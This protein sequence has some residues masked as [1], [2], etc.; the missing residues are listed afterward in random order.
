[1][2]DL[3]FLIEDNVLLRYAGDPDDRIVIP[4]G[5]REIGRYAFANNETVSEIILPEGVEV[6][7]ECAFVGCSWLT[8]IVLPKTLKR[9]E[10][11]A[12]RDCEALEEAKIP[13]GVRE[14][15]RSCFFECLSLKRVSF[16]EGLRVI[17]DKAFSGCT[18]ISEVIFGS[19]LIEIGDFSFELCAGIKR[20]SLPDGLEII[21]K[22]A[23]ASCHQLSDIE[24]PKTVKEIGSGAFYQTEFLESRNNELIIEGDGILLECKSDEKDIVIA[25]GVK[26]ISELAFA[27]DQSLESVVIPEGV[28]IISA[29]A[30][31][32]C[33]S[34]KSVKLPESL[35]VIGDRAFE[36]CAMLYD[37]RLPKGLTS[38]GSGVFGRTPL[39]END[40]ASVIDGRVLYAYRGSDEK[41]VIDES[42][43]MIAGA[44]FSGNNAVKEIKLDARYI[45][46]DAFRWCRA[47]K[48][49]YISK[50]VREIGAYAFSGCDGLK[51]SIECHDIQVNEYAFDMGQEIRSIHDIG[52]FSVILLNANTRASDEQAVFDFC[53]SPNEER[54]LKIKNDEY[55]T[56]IAV[57]FALKGG[58]YERYLSEH[59]KE[60]VCMAV[61]RK[62]NEMLDKALG[63]G[64]LSER[65]AA[66][67]AVY[68]IDN[69]AREQQLMIMRYKQDSFGSVTDKTIDDRFDW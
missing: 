44:A 62:D 39:I 27:Y 34:L 63:Y 36:D 64:S 29:R 38:L 45:C 2:N 17:G 23:F 26:K 7:G 56:P 65:E 53:A 59:I 19:G 10:Q 46:S 11:A 15:P 12:F 40:E 41:P 30:F 57:C 16:P 47:L 14:L 22:H 68:A 66:Q 52:S 60:A 33:S 31:E 13:K 49:V 24:I 18:L 35:R 69:E 37:I 8:R 20:A 50:N 4:E 55:M 42:I 58:E 61:D 28:S 6:I 21:G 5:V 51:A 54:F 9:I 1:M 48:N 67:C 25:E 3:G 32:Q 43:M